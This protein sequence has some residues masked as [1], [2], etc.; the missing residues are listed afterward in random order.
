MNIKNMSIMDS[1]VRHLKKD[2]AVDN[3]VFRGRLTE[4]DV[5]VYTDLTT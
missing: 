5:F 4:K 1:I 3:W 2:K